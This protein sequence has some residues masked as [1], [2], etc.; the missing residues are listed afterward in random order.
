MN[1]PLIELYPQPGRSRELA[2]AWLDLDLPGL[3][4][5]GAPVIYGSFVAS[6]DGRIAV[7]DT[8]SGKLAL[9]EAIVSRHDFRLLQ[10]LMAQADCFVTH[11]GYLRAVASGSLDDILQVGIGADAADLTRWRAAHGFHGQPGIVVASATLDFEVPRSVRDHGQRLTIM[12]VAGAPLERVRHFESQ[13]F[14]VVVAGTGAHVE[15]QPVASMLAQ[16]GYRSA[17]L[18]AGPRM[19][20]TMLRQHQLGRLFL[21]ITHQI[22]GGERFATLTS[23][24][25]LGPA[26]HLRLRTL[27]YDAQQ[28]AGAGQWFAQFEPGG[29]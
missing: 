4:R 3:G 25:L 24:A 21:T 20:D 16:L 18:V 28:P 9:P 22:L 10:E 14:D 17:Y 12:T 19:L 27:Y 13:G 7:A 6:L 23:G 26:G 29:V 2:G 11:G 8:Q 15:A 1:A 5:P